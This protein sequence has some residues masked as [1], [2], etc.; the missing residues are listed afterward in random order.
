MNPFQ[1]RQQ[2]LTRYL[3][4]PDACPAPEG[5]EPRRLAV[6]KDLFYKNIEGFIRGGFPVCHSILSDDKW[7]DL[8]RDFMRVH[9]CQSPY[10][11]QIA[12]EFLHYLG[13]ERDSL[14]D[15]P[16]LHALAHYE[17]VELALDIADATLPPIEAVPP[18]L[19]D[20]PLQ[21][22]PLAWSLSYPYAVHRISMAYQP[23]AVDDEMSY[24]VVY[25]DHGDIVQFMEIN[26]VTARLLALME[27]AVK[28]R[29]CLK[30]IAMESEVELESLV[31]FAEPLL[32]TLYEAGI[33]CPTQ[34][35]ATGD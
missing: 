30:V 35:A 17:W 27:E 29:E 28:P 12:E 5:I 22:S 13:G 14:D 21:R 11:L 34:P 16:F 24:L 10:F 8:V 19:L 31:G 18:F 32:E 6:Y 2:V 4:E 3:R 23:Q 7:H 20:T 1:Q 33:L 25:R 15:P 26:A 9:H